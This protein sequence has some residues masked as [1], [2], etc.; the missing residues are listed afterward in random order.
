MKLIECIKERNYR[1]DIAD[2]IWDWGN[3]FESEVNLLVEEDYDYYDKLMYLF[4]E[5]IDVIKC[6]YDWYTVCDVSGFIWKNL[7]AFSKFMNAA[8]NENFQPCIQGVCESVD[9]YLMLDIYIA[10]FQ[11]LI[12]GN[13]CEEDYEKLFYYLGGEDKNE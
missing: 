13:Y 7:N 9:D 11:E 1:L 5:N 2:N 8:N 10:T 3:Y 4:A 6:N 12:N